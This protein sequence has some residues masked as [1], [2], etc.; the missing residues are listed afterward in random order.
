M[1]TASQGLAF[2]PNGQLYAIGPNHGL[3][4]LDT[5]DAE[6]HYV[7]S[8]PLTV[9][10][11]LCF[12]PDGTLYALGDEF[13]QL[14][15]ATGSQIG[16]SFEIPSNYRGLEYIR[17]AS[18]VEGEGE[19]EGEFVNH[20][21]CP[22]EGTLAGQPA[23]PP[24]QSTGLVYHLS[25]DALW[26]SGLPL[27]V[28]NF[29]I[30]GEVCGFH[31]WG[32]EVNVQGQESERSQ[33]VFVIRVGSDVSGWIWEKTVTSQKQPLGGVW[34]FDAALD[35]SVLLTLYKYEVDLLAGCC[36]LDLDAE[37]LFVSIRSIYMNGQGEMDDEGC[38]FGWAPSLDGDATLWAED[39]AGGG[40]Q[41]L[42][43]VSDNLAFCLTGEAYGP[44]FPDIMPPII[45]VIGLNPFTIQCNSTY[46]DAGATAHDLC[47]GDMTGAMVTTNPV[48][49][50]VPGDYS[51]A[52][53]V[54]DAAGNAAEP[55]IR[56]V[57]V[58]DTIK[59]NLILLGESLVYIECPG[60]YVDAGAAA[61]DSC[62]GDMAASIVI[63]GDSVD[64]ARPGTYI[65]RY[66]VSDS[67]GN[68]APEVMRTV[69]VTD[70]RPPV[71]TLLGED[72][73]TVECGDAYVDAGAT[74]MDACDGDVSSDIIPVSYVDTG[75]PAVFTV[76]YYAMDHRGNYADVAFRTVTVVD[77]T[78]PVIIACTPP[79]PLTPGEGG[80]ATL[81][82]LT[83][84]IVVEDVCGTLTYTQE[85][86]AGTMIVEDTPVA[87]TVT[88]RGGNADVCEMMV[89]VGGSGEGEGEGEVENAEHYRCPDEGILYG[90]AVTPPSP[91]FDLSYHLSD[92]VL[93]S[94][95]YALPVENFTAAGR[96]TAIHWWGVEVHNL[97]TPCERLQSTFTI[98]IGSNRTGVICEYIV[99]P[100]KQDLGETWFRDPVWNTDVLLPLYRYEVVFPT[101]FCQLDPEADDHFLSIRSASFAG[102]DQVMDEGCYFGWA[103]SPEG[104]HD[105]WA[106]AFG[107]VL[108][109]SLSQPSDNLAFCLAG[110]EEGP[111]HPADLNADWRM[112][113]SEAI[114]YLAGWQQGSNPLS[115]AIR[116]AYL[117]Q[118]GESYQYML[119][120]E[121]PLCWTP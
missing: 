34:F 29:T 97:G 116:A 23:I 112:V 55:A 79:G 50:T 65:I 109:M 89:E 100:D 25:D 31:W 42:P 73:I 115:Y 7:G 66:N 94:P 76:N 27:P 14:D 95:Y 10:Q 28:E 57:K 5:D 45:T 106:W 113:I 90:Q 108:P 1:S 8:P 119:G 86:P 15:P 61:V 44:C 6:L 104:N 68:A 99:T 80:G 52:Y 48:D 96:I 64:P 59:P 69:T 114:A 74:A 51:I 103:T 67:S 121:P 54:T 35:T 36:P 87:L 56:T 85:P 18:E 9:R 75:I 46:L 26:K 84:N 58:V 72:F 83:G 63:T 77:T 110:N 70:T 98:K 24:Y 3:C 117:W 16:P 102:P 71:I 19:G 93:W 62:D 120:E 2:A 107:S 118:N 105:L 11:S 12:K 41:V 101:G 82:D 21:V 88:D 49:T 17:G 37:N 53:N 47:D 33:N 78:A 4:T 92:E 43:G 30:K 39:F 60:N 111:V 22:S 20:Y 13:A 32:V 81:P 40:P 91:A 38:Y